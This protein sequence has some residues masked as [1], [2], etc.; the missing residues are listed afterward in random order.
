MRYW[1]SAARYMAVYLLSLI[2]LNHLQVL[3][4]MPKQN[5]GRSKAVPPIPVAAEKALKHPVLDS[6]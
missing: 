3:I 4:E 6:V 1:Q 2:T 5:E